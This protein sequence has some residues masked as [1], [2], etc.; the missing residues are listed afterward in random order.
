MAPSANSNSEAPSLA[1][2]VSSLVLVGCYALYLEF[3]AGANL[4][5]LIERL[6]T[7]SFA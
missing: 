3:G 7:E 6:S 1:G 4:Q 2:I 5:M